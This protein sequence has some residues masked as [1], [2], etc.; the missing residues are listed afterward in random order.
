MFTLGSV[1]G[2]ETY[3]VTLRPID[4]LLEDQEINSIDLIKMDIEGSEY[5]ALCGASRTLTKYRPTLLIELND[6]ALHGCKS[7][8]RDVKLLLCTNGYRG[9][10]IGRKTVQAISDAQVTH[11]CDECL[12]VH[13]DN[14]LLMERLQLL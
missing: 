2:D 5:R 14:K 13:R 3:N 9:W 8:T 1:S 7:S 10:R 4:D 6:V 12:F 11:N